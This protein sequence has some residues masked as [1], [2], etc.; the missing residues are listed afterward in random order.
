MAKVKIQGHASGTGILTVTAPNTSTDRTIT[1]PDASVTLGAATPSITDNGNATAITINSSE[2]VGI[3]VTPTVPLQIRTALSSVG[4]TTPETVLMLETT[5]G[6]GDMAVGNGT[7]ILFKISDDETNPSVGASIDAVRAN[8]DDSLSNTDLVFSTSQNDETL[9]EAMRIDSSGNVGIGVVPESSLSSPITFLG[10]GN[11]IGIYEYDDGGNPVQYNNTLNDRGD[12]KY[13]VNGYASRHQQRDGVHKFQVAPS[14]NADAA[15]SWTTAMTIL[16]N[17]YVDFGAYQNTPTSS[18]GVEIRGIEGQLF[19]SRNGTGSSDHMFIKNSN[20]TVG[21]ISSSGSST[22]YNTSSDY[23]LKENVVPMTGSIDRLKA[24][25]PSRFNFIADPDLI[26]DGFLAHEAQEI[27]PECVT[28][29]KDAM[30]TEEYE[31]TPAVE[32]IT[33]EEGNVT[34]EAVEAV[35]GE[36]EVPDMQGIDQSKL[37][38]LLTSALQEAISK[39]EE[40]TTRIETLET[41]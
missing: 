32:A 34:T 1:L 15:I 13:K 8:G 28:G 36:R 2:Q 23:R 11:R 35:M 25:N 7:R 41:T 24:L 29:E 39:I 18:H 38:P 31:V 30:T 21:R 37:V 17:S 40:L 26:V 27:V 3:G 16:N 9:D 12:E 4:Q 22:Q 20:G 14:G 6:S 10:I 19:S 5:A 33:D